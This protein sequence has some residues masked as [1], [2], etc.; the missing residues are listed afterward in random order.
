MRKPAAT[1]AKGR[2]FRLAL[3]AS[4]GLHAAV[5]VMVGLPPAPMPRPAPV[6]QAVLRAAPPPEPATGLR[7]APGTATGGGA[8][9]ARVTRPAVG[10]PVPVAADVPTA[11]SPAAPS[12]SI[13]PEDSL[14]PGKEA[15]VPAAAPPAPRQPDG[16]ALAAYGQAVAA[17][18]A[19]HQRYPAVAAARRWQG[20]TMLDLMIDAQGW[21]VDVRVA[22]SSGHEVLDQSALLLLAMTG[23]GPCPVPGQLRGIA[24]PGLLRCFADCLPAV[25]LKTAAHRA[26]P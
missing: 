20:T 3:A 24:A 16:S 9:P 26:N 18:L 11:F 15:S 14:A 12:P 23:S 6:L 7:V 19:R 10:P 17:L 21:L 2:A 22:R 25:C 13:A 8:R 4:L 1:G 5:L